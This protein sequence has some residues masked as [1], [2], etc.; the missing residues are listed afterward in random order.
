MYYFKL[1]FFSR[2]VT[3]SQSTLHSLALASVARSHGKRFGN[4]TRPA[5]NVANAGRLATLKNSLTGRSCSRSRFFGGKHLQLFNK[6]RIYL[7]YAIC[8]KFLKIHH[9]TQ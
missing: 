4:K 6:R 1:Y 2:L 7:C 3:W 9:L 5:Q 8:I